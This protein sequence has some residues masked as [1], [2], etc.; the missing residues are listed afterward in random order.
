MLSVGLATNLPEVFTI[1][2]RDGWFVKLLEGSFTALVSVL[3]D[4]SWRS[5]RF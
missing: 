2:T 3:C 5:D 1:T 4:P